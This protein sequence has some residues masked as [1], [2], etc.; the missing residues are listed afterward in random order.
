[1]K[2]FGRE[3]FPVYCEGLV[4]IGGI[5]A[6]S[7]PSTNWAWSI[8]SWKKWF[9]LKAR[10]VLVDC[11]CVELKTCT[12]L[13]LWRVFLGFRGYWWVSL[14]STPLKQEG[15]TGNSTG[16]TNLSSSAPWRTCI[17]LVPRSLDTLEESWSIVSGCTDCL[18][19]W[20]LKVTVGNTQWPSSHHGKSSSFEWSCSQLVLVLSAGCSDQKYRYLSKKTGCVRQLE[21]QSVL[22]QGSGRKSWEERVGS[23]VEQ[24]QHSWS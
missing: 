22:F 21:H 12:V 23:V 16:G 24:V 13:N 10:E 5:C 14:S 19:P 2:S 15:R 17:S 11:G 1:M 20:P 6:Y 4:V 7:G 8:I 18:C 9:F 3:G